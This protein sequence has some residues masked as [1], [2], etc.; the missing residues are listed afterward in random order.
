MRRP[1]NLM[2]TTTVPQLDQAPADPTPPANYVELYGLS[3]QPFGAMPD[4][5]GYV[6]FGSHKRAFELLVDH[7]TKSSGMILLYG[8]EG[9]GKT[10]TIRSVASVAAE[11]GVRTI[12]VSRPANGRVNLMQFIAAIKGQPSADNVTLDDAIAHFLEAPRKALLADDID[13]MPPECVQLLVTLTQR[14]AKNPNGPAIVLSTATDLTT[15]PRRAEFSP[16]IALARNTVRLP[17]LSPAESK[18]YIE[19]SLWKAGSTTRRLIATDAMK[20]IITRSGG[21][22]GLTDRLMEAVLTAGFARGDAMITAK[23]VAAATGS[24]A[25]RTRHRISNPPGVAGRAMQFISI[26]LL[27]AGASAFLY[28]GLTDPFVPQQAALQPPAA[29]AA[30][31][32]AMPPRSAVHLPPDVVSALMKRGD[33]SLSLGDVA[34]ARLLYRRA[35][36]AGNAAAAVALGRTY[37]PNS[38]TSGSRPEPATAAEWY[39]E[40][41]RL[42]DP[43][44]AELLKK[45]DVH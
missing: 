4:P 20:P 45:L 35:A 40:A 10:A 3:K 21:L 26:T 37:D 30:A 15:E 5:R 43:H 18:Q 14:T 11:S 31:G 7:V 6:L 39:Q 28:R 44:A 8:E 25:P 23:T 12:V 42:G 32:Q 1:S 24:G 9:I 29:V 2:I 41:V 38:V 22:P 19:Q 13:L 33:Q 17:R 27:L 16:V 34:A 36:E